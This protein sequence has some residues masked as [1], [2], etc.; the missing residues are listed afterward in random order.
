MLE[1]PG[2]AFIYR[3][4]RLGIEAFMSRPFVTSELVDEFESLDLESAS[5]DTKGGSLA[6]S[7]LVVLEFQEAGLELASSSSELRSSSVSYSR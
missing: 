5:Q 7:R 3:L 2:F 4:L 6:M 1:D